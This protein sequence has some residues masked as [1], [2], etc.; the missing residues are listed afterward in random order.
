[1]FS[2][3]NVARA[4]GVKRSGNYPSGRGMLFDPAEGLPCREYKTEPLEMSP[5]VDD[6]SCQKFAGTLWV[7][8]VK[9]FLVQRKQGREM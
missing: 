1:M 2:S 9:R 7:R 4:V 5:A 3:K 8:H 6:L